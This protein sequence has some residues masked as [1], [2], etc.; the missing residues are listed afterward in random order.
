MKRIVF[1][2][3]LIIFAGSLNSCASKK[4]GCG[5][6]AENQEVKLQQEV[7]LAEVAE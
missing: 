3:A 5:L 1:I 6:T 7:V 2:L 4:K